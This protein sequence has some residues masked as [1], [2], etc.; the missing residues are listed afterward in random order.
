MTT[1]KFRLRRVGLVFGR[2]LVVFLVCLLVMPLV[3]LAEASDH[4]VRANTSTIPG[5]EYWDAGFN[6][7]GMNDGVYA[8]AVGAD[9][10]LYAGGSFTTAGKT[11]ANRIARWDGARWYPLG[12]GMNGYFIYALAVGADG[13][14]YAGGSFTT[15]GGV[16]ANYIARW[17]GAQWHPLGSGVNREVNALAVGADGSLYAGGRFTTAGGVPANYIA[18]WDGTQWHPLA[19]GM[20]G[21]SG[22]AVKALVH[23]G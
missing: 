3:S 12:S 18:R 7:P 15:A 20:A 17:D 6:A 4:S 16:A 1:N 13:S 8:L 23:V 2:A 11:V 9:G 14:L 22:P 19:S 10:S 5:D 21:D